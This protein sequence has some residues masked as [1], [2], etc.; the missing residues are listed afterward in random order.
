MKLFL[1]EMFVIQFLHG[2]CLPKNAYNCIGMVII[3][4]VRLI[5]IHNYSIRAIILSAMDSI[6]GKR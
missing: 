6:E 5:I 3:I 2:S 1:Y 4:E